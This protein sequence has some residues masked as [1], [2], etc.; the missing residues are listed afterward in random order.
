MLL[1]YSS[2]SLLFG[3][4]NIGS[5][6]VPTAVEDI[7]FVV[8]LVAVS[9][10]FIVAVVTIVILFLGLPVV[11]IRVVS[12]VVE[13][14]L[15]LVVVILRVSLVVDLFV[16]GLV[17]V[18]TLAVTHPVEYTLFVV[19]RANF[20]VVV[21]FASSSCGCQHSLCRCLRRESPRCLLFFWWSLLFSVVLAG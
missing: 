15:L 12:L 1:S 7:F 2:S 4:V 18:N 10:L 9:G 14:I 16:V 20:F 21:I 13:D 5:L 17:V 19:S 3:L 8:P 11:S 6:L